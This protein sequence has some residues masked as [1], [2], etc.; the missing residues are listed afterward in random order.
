MDMTS[1]RGGQLENDDGSDGSPVAFWP[2]LKSAS[3]FL[4]SILEVTKTLVTV[5]KDGYNH[6]L[7]RHMA[8]CTRGPRPPSP[9]AGSPALRNSPGERITGFLSIRIAEDRSD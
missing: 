4:A 3:F 1:Q 7:Q 2:V 5:W 6:L 8:F 9:R